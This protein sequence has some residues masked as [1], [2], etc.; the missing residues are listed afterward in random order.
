MPMMIGSI[1]SNEGRTI[2][3]FIALISRET[4]EDFEWCFSSFINCFPNDAPINIIRDECPSFG[5]AIKN[6]FAQSNH[7]ICGWH[8]SQNIMKI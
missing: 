1:V 8:K 6:K 2:I 4:A 3:V 5:K 7:F